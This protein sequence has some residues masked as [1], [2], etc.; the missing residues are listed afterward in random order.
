[1]IFKVGTTSFKNNVVIGTYDI[2]QVPVYDEWID[3]NGT[4]H[5]LKTRDKIQGSLDLFFRT[6]TDYSTFKTAITNNTSS[7]NM[8]VTIS[9][10]V[11]NTNSDATGI[12]AYMDFLPVRDV[13]GK[14]T[15]F[16]KVIKVNIE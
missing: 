12:S 3:A 2:N 5:R 11:N 13:D 8:S 14:R 10:T 7:S 16:F 9:V 4:S 1:M 6:L 15:E